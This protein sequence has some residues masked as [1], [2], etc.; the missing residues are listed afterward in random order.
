MAQSPTI[1][2]VRLARLGP[3]VSRTDFELDCRI[4]VS[5]E[6]SWNKAEGSCVTGTPAVCSSLTKMP[7]IPECLYTRPVLHT[8]HTMDHDDPKAPLAAR[9]HR[10]CAGSLS[11]HKQ[12]GK[13]FLLLFFCLV[14]Y[15][16]IWLPFST[17]CKSDLFIIGFDQTYLYLLYVIISLS[18]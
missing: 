15:N 7:L 8:H 16:T 9:N 11:R 10:W 17:W 13:W 18:Y 4:S 3:S 1:K 12:I 2:G 14:Y 6:G 5:P